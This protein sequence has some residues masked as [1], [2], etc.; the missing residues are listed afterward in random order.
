MR[1]ER[2]RRPPSDHE[3]LLDSRRFVLARVQCRDWISLSG[4]SLGLEGS[5]TA[6]HFEG[7]RAPRVEQAG[8]L[9]GRDSI[10]LRAL[11]SRTRLA[12]EMKDEDRC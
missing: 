1:E 4:V 2:P 3:F 11:F 12:L 6:S 9:E 10:C 8:I 5:I 7:A